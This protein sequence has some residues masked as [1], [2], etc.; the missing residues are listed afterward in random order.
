MMKVRVI[1][2]KDIVG[3]VEF[4]RVPCIR[5]GVRISGWLYEVISVVHTVDAENWVA[6][7]LVESVL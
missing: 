5:E 1:T 2:E 6:T 4:S 7:L 3:V